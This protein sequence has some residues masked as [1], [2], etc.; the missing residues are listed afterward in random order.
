MDLSLYTCHNKILNSISQ[1][2][3]NTVAKECKLVQFH[4][5]EVVYEST[6]NIQ[7]IYFPMDC[8]ISLI[9]ETLNGKASEIASIGNNGA[10][11]VNF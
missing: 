4:T 6:I 10:V 11:G 3:F 1:S 9:Y 5:G 7:Y 8:I 2:D